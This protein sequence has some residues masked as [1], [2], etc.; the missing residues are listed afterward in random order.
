MENIREEETPPRR[1]A[2]AYSHNDSR[3]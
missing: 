3:R 2:E 1:I